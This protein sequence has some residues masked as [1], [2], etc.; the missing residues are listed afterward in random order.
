VRKSSTPAIIF[1]LFFLCAVYFSVKTGRLPTIVFMAYAALSLAAFIAYAIDKSA[2]QR[3]AWR[4]REGT[5]HMFGLLG[6]WPGALVAQ[7]TL[8][9]KSKKVSFRVGFWFTVLVNCAALV[10]LHTENGRSLLNMALN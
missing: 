6:G 1:A 5:L 9:H 4:I 2:A 10:W 8:R 3:G 7:Q